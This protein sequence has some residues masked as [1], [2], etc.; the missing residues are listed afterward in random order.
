MGA[1]LT[2]SY[3]HRS[4]RRK[5]VEIGQLDNVQ[6]TCMASKAKPVAWIRSTIYSKAGW[7]LDVQ[8]QY[9]ASAPV[10]CLGESPSSLIE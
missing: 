6:T 5:L 2:C 9:D 4:A 7:S 3:L 1:G 8:P 10:A